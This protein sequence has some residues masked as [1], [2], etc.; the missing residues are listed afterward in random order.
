MEVIRAI[1][2]TGRQTALKIKGIFEQFNLSLE[3]ELSPDLAT[4]IPQQWDIIITEKEINE[5]INLPIILLLKRSTPEIVY[6]KII[7]GYEMAMDIGGLELLPI[8]ALKAITAREYKRESEQSDSIMQLS[9]QRYRRL[10]EAAKDAIV[11]INGVNNKVVDVNPCALEMLKSDKASVLG[12]PIEKC[13]LEMDQAIIKAIVDL[14]QKDTARTKAEIKRV[15]GTVIFVDFV[16]SR[17]TEAGHNIIQGSFRDITEQH[18]QEVKIQKIFEQIKANEERY[19]M[20]VDQ[21]PT[22]IIIADIG[23]GLVEYANDQAEIIFR[24]PIAS[25]AFKSLFTNP[26]RGEEILQTILECGVLLDHEEELELQD[27][28]KTYVVMNSELVTFS[29]RRVVHSILDIK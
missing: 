2:Y 19:R 13:V 27:A 17:F 11:V 7:A 14:R 12:K 23:T 3:Y 22:A 15:D 9:E 4:V 28:E 10:F 5:A 25:I 20:L 24:R 6:E 26:D 1:L 18:E 16:A 8:I 29:G 21:V